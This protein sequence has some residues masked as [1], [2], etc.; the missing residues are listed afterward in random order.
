MET[1]N[2]KGKHLEHQGSG[3]AR[4]KKLAIS[5]QQVMVNNNQKNMN[6]VRSKKKREGLMLQDKN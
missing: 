2:D 3:E 5:R 1:V 6:K 4:P